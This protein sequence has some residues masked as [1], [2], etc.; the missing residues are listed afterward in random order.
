MSDDEEMEEFNMNEEDLRRAYDPTSTRR[1]KQTKEE[2]MLG[3]F[4]A[5]DSDEEEDERFDYR[6]QKKTKSSLNFI[7]AGIVGSKKKSPN[8]LEEK[9]EENDENE[10]YSSGED[11]PSMGFDL[12]KATSSKVN[13]KRIMANLDGFR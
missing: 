5:S 2:A 13:P 3:I 4:A 1:K 8:N 9:D 10:N 12:K 6:N 11:D 7:S